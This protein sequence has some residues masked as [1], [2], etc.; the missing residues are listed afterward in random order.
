MPVVSSGARSYSSG[1]PELWELSTS[2]TYQGEFRRQTA[3]A[4]L[5]RLFE[6]GEAN[7]LFSGFIT[8]LN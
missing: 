8:G 7:R 3:R 1:I 2:F 4:D 6:S 5:E